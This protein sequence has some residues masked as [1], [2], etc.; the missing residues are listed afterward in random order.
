MGNKK[1]VI[2][3]AE[4]L[5]TG[6]VLKH[7]NKYSVIMN[8]IQNQRELLDIVNRLCPDIAIVDDVIAGSRQPITFL[9]DL[10]KQCAS[11]RIILI[12]HCL[13]EQDIGKTE[14][15]ELCDVFRPGQTDICHLEHLIDGESALQASSHRRK[16]K[17]KQMQNTDGNNINPYRNKTAIAITGADNTGKTF[18]SNAI[19]LH[20]ANSGT[21]TAIIDMS[22]NR[23]LYGI[24]CWGEKRSYVSSG[25]AFELLCNGKDNP[26]YIN[27][28]LALYTSSKKLKQQIDCAA[29]LEI[30]FCTNDVLIFDTDFN[31]NPAFYKH[32]NRIG[33]V[34]DMDYL[35]IIQNTRLIKNLKQNGV[36][37][38]KAVIVL[39]K[40]V[41]CGIS[42][43]DIRKQ[44]CIE[45][46]YDTKSSE[47]LLQNCNLFK[48]NFSMQDYIAW[49]QHVYG[50]GANP[51]RYTN[52]MQEDIDNLICNLL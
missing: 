3:S 41:K 11:C 38:K 50:G 20:M 17:T 24:Y 27:S 33:I 22:R 51:Q 5:I 39:N 43:K 28:N 37:L 15:E 47:I 10:K 8:N 19:A 26:F 34:Q 18:I 6:A 35:N 9:H 1:I 14:T 52:E 7:R 29:M 25:D 46:G 44:L 30:L 36:N 16:A 12:A 31:T 4:A 13:P 2:A 40:Y 23:T 45:Q 48:V 42:I 21:K 49:I 32:I